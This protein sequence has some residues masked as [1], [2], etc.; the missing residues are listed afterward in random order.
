MATKRLKRGTYLGGQQMAAVVGMHPYMS[1]GDVYAHAVRGAKSITDEEIHGEP[2]KPSVLRRGIIC[3]EGVISYIETMPACLGLPPGTLER[4]VFVQ[5]K[6]IPF[7]A[8]TIDACELDDQGRI[9]HIHEITV[10]ST[11]AVDDHWGVDGDP[12]GCAKYKWI[13]NVHYQG[14]SGAGGGTVWLFVSDTGEIRRYP[15]VRNEKA[16][17]QLRNDGEQFWLEHVLPKKPPKIECTSIG[18]W[19]VAEKS[20]DAIYGIGDGGPI[21]ATEDIV[22]ASK[23]YDEARQEVKDAEDRKRGAAAMLKAAL[24][25]HSSSK[26]K[27]GSVSWKR[28]RPSSKVN[29][30]HAFKQLAATQGL[31]DEAVAEFLKQHT[32]LKNGPRVM[33]VTLKKEKKES[34]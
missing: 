19:A 14:I 13:Q 26:W 9:S 16:I 25:D 3:E 15:V 6:D 18:A 5:D 31:D 28:N 12:N 4:D 20:L 23:L 17:E 11:R 34:D 22:K 10:T 2:H 1:L 24:G 27:G 30:E 21:D 33:R 8:G 7:F 29:Y 32:H